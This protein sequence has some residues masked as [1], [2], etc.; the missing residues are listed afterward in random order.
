M[1]MGTAVYPRLL[2]LQW[3]TLPALI[4][5]NGSCN[6]VSNVCLVGDIDTLFTLIPNA[7]LNLQS[8]R[9][10]FFLVSEGLRV[11]F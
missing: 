5:K 10:L 2:S 1:R 9:P 11:C 8:I 4:L 3:Y 6:A 7:S